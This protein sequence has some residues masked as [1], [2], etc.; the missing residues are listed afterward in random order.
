MKFKIEIN[1][2]STNA[3]YY[4][5]KNGRTLGYILHGSMKDSSKLKSF[6]IITSH[7]RTGG[8]MPSP[9]LVTMDE[10]VLA[11]KE[12]FDKFNVK[13]PSNFNNKTGEA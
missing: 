13:V 6:G 7:E 2:A 1:E 4:V 9:I 8:G 5:T 11:K 12:D 10:L 3:T